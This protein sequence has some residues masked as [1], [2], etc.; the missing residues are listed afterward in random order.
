MTEGE[1][2]EIWF[3]DPSGTDVNGRLIT[4][5]ELGFP[6][7]FDDQGA[8]TGTL[9]GP[10]SSVTRTGLSRACRQAAP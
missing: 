9:P 2:N 7:D 1:K 6:P 5:E 10:R 4:D 3:S 8:P